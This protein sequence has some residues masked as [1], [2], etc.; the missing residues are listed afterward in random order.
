[1]LG[2][3]AKKFFGSAN[4]RYVN[5]VQPLIDKINALEA[6]MGA[7]SDEKLAARTGWLKKRHQEGES[8]DDLLPDAF[9][10]AREAAQRTLGERHYAA[11]LM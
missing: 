11:R 9:A 3:F 5:R 6:E 1:M 8:L 10:T 4:E 7:L 2:N